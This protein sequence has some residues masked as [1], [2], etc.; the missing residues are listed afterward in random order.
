[1]LILA[2]C[3]LITGYYYSIAYALDCRAFRASSCAQAQPLRSSLYYC[4]YL[5]LTYSLLPTN[6]IPS[7]Y[8]TLLTYTKLSTYY[9]PLS[10]I[11]RTKQR[12]NLLGS[13]QPRKDLASKAAC[14]GPRKTISKTAAKAKKLHCFKLGSMLSQLFIT[15]IF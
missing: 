13:K 3:K 11:A 6:T 8:Y 9:T 5:Y 2:R 7:T 10:T 14:K 4:C 15:Y 12:V 1:L